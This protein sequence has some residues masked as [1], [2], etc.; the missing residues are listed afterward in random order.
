MAPIKIL[1][2]VLS[3]PFDFKEV[4]LA[5]IENAENQNALLK[6]NGV[7]SVFWESFSNSLKKGSITRF[8]G[9]NLKV[10]HFN[11]KENDNITGI[12]QVKLTNLYPFYV[13]YCKENNI[14]FLDQG[15]LRMIL[16][17][18]SNLDFVCGSQK[19]RAMAYTDKYFGSCYQFCYSKSG[20]SIYISEIEINL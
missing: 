14:T 11:I 4:L 13:R 1:G 18:R 19:G 9:C 3:F 17:S 16:T 8:D 6:Q 12:I 5:T 2:N 10:A 7:S 20:N 15:G